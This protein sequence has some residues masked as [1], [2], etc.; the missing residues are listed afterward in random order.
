[1]ASGETWPCV[2]C[3]CIHIVV[4]DGVVWRAWRGV[5][6][7]LTGSRLMT[8]V[9]CGTL[10]YAALHWSFN[11]FVGAQQQLATPPHLLLLAS[12]SGSGT[13]TATGV[14]EHQLGRSRQH[15]P[16]PMQS[17]LATAPIAHMNPVVTVALMVRLAVVGLAAGGALRRAVL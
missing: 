15:H 10:A 4:D 9:L 13:T 7:E 5:Q 2:N 17:I 8:I 11:L 1:M 16:S 6:T 3:S 12:G 14:S